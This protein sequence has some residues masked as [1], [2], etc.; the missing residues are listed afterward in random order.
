MEE[1]VKKSA[2]EILEGIDELKEL[3]E[4][5]NEFEADDVSDEF[6]RAI[7]K[8]DVLMEDLRNK[9]Q[10]LPEETELEARSIGIESDDVTDELYIHGLDETTEKLTKIVES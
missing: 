1:W 8:V 9:L 4:R 6:C 5:V 7:E 2:S 10:E 3:V